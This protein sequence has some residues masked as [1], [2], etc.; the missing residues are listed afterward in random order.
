[1]TLILW[2]DRGGR[3]ASYVTDPGDMLAMIVDDP[4][5]TLIKIVEA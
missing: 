5:M 3:Y 4:T 2:A 1:M